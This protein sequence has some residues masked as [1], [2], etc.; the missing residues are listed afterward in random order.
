MFQCFMPYYFFLPT[1]LKCI[2]ENT[3][4]NREMCVSHQRKHKIVSWEQSLRSPK[5]HKLWT[6]A[7]G[8]HVYYHEV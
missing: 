1:N 5:P 2:G 4:T 3:T 8:V 7:R 6:P